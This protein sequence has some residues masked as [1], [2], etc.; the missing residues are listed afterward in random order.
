MTDR[1]DDR[2][3]RARLWH[4]HGLGGDAF[5]NVGDVVRSVVAFH[6]TDPATVHLGMV[7]RL[8]AATSD[9]LLSELHDGSLVKVHAMRRTVFF[10]RRADQP[11]FHAAVGAEL[12][13]KERRAVAQLLRSADLCEAWLNSVSSSVCEVLSDGTP[14]TGVTLGGLEPRL[15]Q[16]VRAP[17]RATGKWVPVGSRILGL[18]AMQGRIERASPRG[19][20]QSNQA[21]WVLAPALEPREPAEAR[22]W[23]LDAYLHQYGPA[24]VDD[25]VW[26][27][28][29]GK[30]VVSATLA[31]LDPRAVH[32]ANGGV[33]MIAGDDP[34][35]GDADVEAVAPGAALLPALD[36]SVMGWKLREWYL[37]AAF[38]GELMD[39]TGNIGPTVWWDG[40]VVG[41]W[42]H[43]TDGRVMWEFLAD[44]P[45]H[46]VA[47]IACEAERIS[48]V[49]GNRT[50]KPRFRTPLELRLAHGEPIDLGE[51]GP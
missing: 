33:A 19:S 3:R 14:R 7:A 46:A 4:R 22:R 10:V 39:R 1:L 27:T 47:A 49:I 23:L 41:G 26:W 24:T 9:R 31:D 30:K 45:A 43:R 51:V 44:V 21:T 20:W 8:P 16:Q 25:I 13:V 35:A 37:P 42:G 17:G 34:V 48:A 11:M 40:K 50:V 2:D 38:L 5:F 12:E 29:W 32:L 15:R 18:L 36:P 6:A 28:G